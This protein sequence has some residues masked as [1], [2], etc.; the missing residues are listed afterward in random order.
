[1][2][3]DSAILTAAIL[4]AIENDFN[5]RAARML[6][7]RLALSEK[8]NAQRALNRQFERFKVAPRNRFVIGE[9][10]DGDLHSFEVTLTCAINDIE[11]S[12]E[13]LF[14]KRVIEHLP[15]DYLRNGTRARWKVIEQQ[16]AHLKRAAA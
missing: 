6:L 1:M 8:R 14:L 5:L 12:Y 3:E 10:E 13:Y 16:H 11:T 4:N 7:S 9:V 2:N 15:N